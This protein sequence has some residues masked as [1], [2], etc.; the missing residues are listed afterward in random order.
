MNFIVI[1]MYTINSIYE[2]V[3]VELED[4]MKKFNIPYKL[5]AITDRGSW[6]RNCQYK[7]IVIRDALINFNKPV[8]WVDA[9]A[10]FQKPPLLF[11]NLT[12]DFAYHHYKKHNEV[13]SG[14]LFFR[15]TEKSMELLNEWISLNRT[16][17]EWDQRNLRKLLDQKYRDILDI[18]YLPAEYCKIFDNRW[19]ECEEEPIIIH[20]QASRTI[21]YGS[22]YKKPR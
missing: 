12:C 5:Y 14:T 22:K 8:V 16:N 1:S 19:Q 20:Y 17:T 6:E 10:V 2:D 7:T 18:I 11:N 13:L 3:V 9:D 21:K 4:S 15:P